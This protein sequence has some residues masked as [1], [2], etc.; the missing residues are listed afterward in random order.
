MGRSLSIT[1]ESARDLRNADADEGGESDPYV[2]ICLDNNTEQELGRTETASDTS[3]P[4]W[5]YSFDVDVTSHIER[6]IE[7]TGKE[8]QMLTFCVY[9]GDEG[10]SEALGVA[11]ISFG[12]LVKNGKYEGEIPVFMGNG[13]V[14]VKVSMKKVKIGSMLKDNTAL[15][16]AGGVAGVAALG[17][18]GTFIYQKYEKK[19]QKLNEDEGVE[20]TRTGFAYGANIDDDDDDEEERGTMKPW[21]EMEDA[22]DDTEED[23]RWTNLADDEY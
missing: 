2:I 12:D 21:Y 16:V 7:Q 4:E 5:N 15:K 19:K 18:L 13:F 11:G 10:S 9:D 6:A 23:N 3:N 8:P 1:V 17:A 22:D 20:D 14:T